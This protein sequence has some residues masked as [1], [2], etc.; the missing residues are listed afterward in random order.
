MAAAY[1]NAL[2]ALRNALWTTALVLAVALALFSWL[3]PNHYY[4]W[5]TF[6]GQLA[7]AGAGALLAAW[8]FAGPLRCAVRL[9]YLAIVAVVAA[10]IP[11]VQFASGLIFFSGDA[12]MP[13]LYLLGFALAQIVGFRIVA[14]YG[15]RSLFE[16]LAWLFVAASILSVWLALYQWQGLSYLGEFG[17]YVA[18]GTR[19]YANLAQPNLLATLLTLGLIGCA[20][21]YQLRRIGGLTAGL[22]AALLV[23]GIAMTQSR[24]GVVL[25]VIVGG[26]LALYSRRS[27]VDLRALAL[28][29]VWL[30]V[31]VAAWPHFLE[32]SGHGEGRGVVSAA[33]AGNR[34]IHWLS[35][36]DASTRSPWFGYG[37]NQ[38]SVAHYAVAPD[39]P[40]TKEVLGDSHN[41]IIDLL[42]WNGLPIGLLLTAA[43]GL[44]FVVMVTRRHSPESAIA[45]APVIAVFAHSMIEFPI[46]YTYFM[47]PIALLMGGLVAT[48]RPS[49]SV[50]SPRWAAPLVLGGVVFVVASLTPEYLK[51]EAEV[52]AKRFELAGL[53]THKPPHPP[54][55]VRWLT[56]HGN[57]L[58]LVRTP[59]SDSLPADE[60]AW[61]GKV[62]M[63]YP[64]WTVVTRYASALARDDRP[65]EARAA[66]ARICRIRS[67]AE[68][69]A[70]QERWARLAER[71]AKIAA[72]H[73]P[74]LPQQ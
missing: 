66:L 74:T 48:L 12:L 54:T 53:G 1:L 73:F 35:M 72:I 28:V 56:Q 42:V 51:I 57:F 40:P 59:D 22:T 31:C 6:H 23:F 43:V 45:L 37:W 7:M 46:Y 29:G 69:E 3:S 24:A 44:W 52:L 2:N 50:G 11:W 9:P 49:D 17:L 13:S 38:V 30:L 65:A 68:C 5:T 18:K 33:S 27:R 41:L 16:P 71:S 47:L 19:P 15:L 61:I 63:R 70:A 4:P 36:L 10:A 39:Y 20:Y 60:I 55:E 21:V 62:A 14:A 32:T 8:S 26:W 25:L 67:A 64:N 34:P 58:R